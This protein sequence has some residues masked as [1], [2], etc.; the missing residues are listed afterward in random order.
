MCEVVLEWKKLRGTSQALM[1][2]VSEQRRIETRGRDEC[3]EEK[4]IWNAGVKREGVIFLI[5][6]GAWRRFKRLDKRR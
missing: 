2:V 4:C 6:S 1:K 5:R 3:E